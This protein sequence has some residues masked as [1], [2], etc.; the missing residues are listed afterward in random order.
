MGITDYLQFATKIYAIG[1]DGTEFDCSGKYCVGFKTC[2]HYYDDMP[3]LSFSFDGVSEPVT[4]D[5]WSYAFSEVESDLG[6]KTGPCTVAITFLPDDY[7][8]ALLGANFLRQY[9]ASFNY[10]DKTV[11]LGKSV[12]APQKPEIAKALNHFLT[13]IVIFVLLV[14]TSSYNQLFYSRIISI[15]L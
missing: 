12:N 8:V 4:L 5:P 2:D 14:I 6:E 11:T 10:A 15:K 9:V 13:I 1:G 3:T 7:G